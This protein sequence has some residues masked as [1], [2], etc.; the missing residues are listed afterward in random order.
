MILL[1]SIMTTLVLFTACDPDNEKSN[2]T[3]TADTMSETV[4]MKEAETEMETETDME[5]ETETEV[6]TETEAETET[7]SVDYSAYTPHYEY[8]NLFAPSGSGTATQISGKRTVGTHIRVA[9][10]CFLSTLSFVCPSW[11]N[12]IGEMDVFF[13]RWDTDRKTTVASEPVFSYHIKDTPDNCAIAIHLPEFTIGEGEWYYEFC[14][15]SEDMIGVWVG[16]IAP[17]DAEA[18]VTTVEGYINGRSANRGVQAHTTY[19]RYE[20][21]AEEPKPVDPA[22]YTQLTE[23]KAHV[24]VLTGQSNAAGQSLHALLKNHI[25]DEEYAM[26]EQGFE[27]ILIDVHADNG[28]AGCVCTN[29]FV[30]VKLGQG[31]FSER[32]GIEVGLAA[33]LTKTYPGETFYIIKSGFSASGLA[34]HWQDGQLCHNLF[35]ANMEKSL[36]RLKSMGL[37]PEIFAF[38]WMQGE[39]DACYAEDTERYEVLQN[40]LIERMHTRYAAYDAPGGFAF[41]DA[42]ISDRACWMYATIVNQMKLA[43]DSLSQNR[44]FLDTNT[45]DIDCRDENNDLAHYDSDDMLELGT[46]FGE[47][48]GQVIEN[49]KLAKD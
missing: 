2:E 20:A 38:L 36:N 23:G 19:V 47:A 31:A 9:A 3:Q 43:C 30:P 4:T 29:G 25:S 35:V 16:Q 5:I 42:A 26:Y 18:P 1:L 8:A 12:S 49:A 27:N 37:E 45:P 39:T 11:N 44:Y 21:A 22:G 24:I 41:I 48:V 28:N 7:E 34:K 46:L 14:N 32:F 17:E 10:D 33:Y 40:D 13:Y 15:G 6:E